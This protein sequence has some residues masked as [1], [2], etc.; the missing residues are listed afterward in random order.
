MQSFIQLIKY[1]R[2]KNAGESGGIIDGLVHCIDLAVVEDMNVIVQ[3]FGSVSI[4]A[5]IDN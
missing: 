1:H 4:I 2:N 5:A 3:V